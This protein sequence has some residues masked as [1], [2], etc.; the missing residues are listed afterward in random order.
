VAPQIRINPDLILMDEPSEGLAPIII[1]EV[2]DTIN[3]LR[4]SNFSILL[5]EQN[6]DMAMKVADYV[7]MV[8]KG[9][10]PY[11]STKDDFWNNEEIKNQYL[12]VRD[13][14]RSS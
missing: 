14:Y 1:Q 10:I 5:V 11:E 2:V 7:Y 12:G 9:R 8:S 3:E 6:F 4:T 13:G